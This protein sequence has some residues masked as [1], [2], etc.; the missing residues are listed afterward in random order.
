MEGLDQY[1]KKWSATILIESMNALATSSRQSI[2]KKPTIY[3]KG[4]TTDKL[5]TIRPTWRSEHGGLCIL[6]KFQIDAS[7]R[8]RIRTGL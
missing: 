4:A 5:T 6:R 3:V 1:D 7:L 2:V 8:P